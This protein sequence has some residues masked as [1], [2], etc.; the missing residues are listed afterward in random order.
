[1][2][3]LEQ[4]QD[5][6]EPDV[7]EA[8]DDMFV[9]LAKSFNLTSGDMTPDEHNE[10]IDAKQL[11]TKVVA[12]WIMGNCPH[13]EW[14]EYFM[15]CALCSLDYDDLDDDEKRAMANP[16]N[17]QCDKC[18]KTLLDDEAEHEAEYVAKLCRNCKDYNEAKE[19]R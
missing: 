2:T 14:D 5:W 8:I 15:K 18:L 7:S 16:D 4:V 13:I 12:R 10:L 9:S 1:M 6:I 11:M 19:Q 17:G 3:R